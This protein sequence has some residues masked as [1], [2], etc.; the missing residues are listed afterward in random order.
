[1]RRET[2]QQRRSREERTQD[3]F[4]GQ[5][6]IQHVS[7]K[8]QLVLLALLAIS[9]TLHIWSFMRF[10]PP[11][12]DESWLAGRAWGFIETNRAFGPLDQGVIDRFEGYWTFF[13]WLHVWIQS[14][15]L[16]LSTA[17]ALL[18]LR[19]VS[20]LFG[21]LL[22][23]PVYS[24][25]KRLYGQRLGLLAVFLVSVS[26]PFL[27]SAHL[28][29][30]DIITATFG[31]TAIALYLNNQPTRLWM[32]L[33]S[34]LCVGLAFEI[35]P[36]GIVYGPTI[37]TLY[38][39][40]FRWSMFRRRHFWS[41]VI[42]V[43]IGLVFYAFLHILRYPGT[44]LALNRLVFVGTHTPPILTLDPEVILRAF[45]EMGRFL[46]GVNPA[47]IPILVWAALSLTRRHSEADKTLLV[48]NAALLVG[49]T[50]LFRTK[51]GYYAILFTPATELLVAVFLL[52]YLQ[53]PWHGQLRDY[54]RHAL[55]WGAGIGAIAIIVSLVW[56]NSWRL[57]QE[58]QDYVSQVVQ[59]GESVMA[60]QIYWLGLYEHK[61]YSWETLVYYQRYVPGSTLADALVEFRPDILIIDPH[62][63]SFI[64]DE[65]G[66]ST[67][68]QHKLLPRTEM[69]AFL[70]RNASLIGL[71]DIEHYGPIHVFRIEWGEPLPGS[72]IGNGGTR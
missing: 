43:G 44:Y 70:S 42:G 40:H 46:V 15:A 59:P 3:S 53:Q 41:F 17:P 31:F 50:V 18:P 68:L 55:I 64:S 26:L 32:S 57:Y 16:R 58:A 19:I 29:R 63:E 23:A 65:P 48:L 14:L 6:M 27:Y 35:H 13:P 38:F 45:V 72:E 56:T 21:L 67:S 39:L 2:P 9:I 5:E 61:Y 71:L 8:G 52:D 11:F 60:S 51:T 49:V 7:R 34:G 62:L 28:A 22:L 36:H 1:M 4:R 47:L 24:I 12:V 54:A 25:G 33:V 30:Q 37:G 69:N 66:E 20:L 10:P